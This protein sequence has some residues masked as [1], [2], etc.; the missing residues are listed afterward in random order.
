MTRKHEVRRR[1]ERMEARHEPTGD[2]VDYRQ[3]LLDRLEAQAES[4]RL[5]G[6][7]ETYDP[8]DIVADCDVRIAAADIEFRAKQSK[9]AELLDGRGY[10]AHAKT[11]ENR[12]HVRR[13]VA[14]GARSAM[15]IRNMLAPV[16]A[17]AVAELGR[18]VADAPDVRFRRPVASFSVAEIVTLHASR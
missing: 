10:P 12:G 3:V 7:W 5:S 13:N 1:L 2:G 8:A 9:A 18:P 15:N 6:G 16:R 17:T 4:L 14:E 11:P